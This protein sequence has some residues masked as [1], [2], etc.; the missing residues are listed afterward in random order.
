MT[1][2][3]TTHHAANAPVP[4]KAAYPK[5]MHMAAS[6]SAF[7]AGLLFLAGFIA[8]RASNAGGL[9]ALLR[10]NWLITIFRLLAGEAGLRASEL[11]RLNALDLILL[12]L[13]AVTHAGLYRTLH[14]S[15][16]VLALIGVVQPP[17][18]I[19]LFV[20]THSAGRSAAMGATMVLSVAMLGSQ[21]FDKWT[22][23]MGLLASI[24]LLA[25]DFGTGLAPNSALALS[26]ELGYMLL[27]AWL[28]LVGLR[29]SRLAR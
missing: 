26:T 7:S 15:R 19:L 5:W 21:V 22:G 16:R 29:F 4:G 8:L 17:L 28:F 3:V 9:L 10:G 1:T 13:I 18:G 24:L 6:A 25:G 11:Y 2:Q 27:A 14:S 23:W 20:L 12:A